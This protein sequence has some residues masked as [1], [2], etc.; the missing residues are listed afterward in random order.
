MPKFTHEPWCDP[1]IDHLIFDVSCESETIEAPGVWATLQQQSLD[2][3]EPV[4]HLHLGSNPVDGPFDVELS[5]RA[6]LGLIHA[7]HHRSDELTEV[8]LGTVNGAAGRQVGEPADGLEQ[9]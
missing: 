2:D 3:K 8:L 4:I 9:V 6:A 7:V 1:K 5:T